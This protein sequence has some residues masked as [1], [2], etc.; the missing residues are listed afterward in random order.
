[1]SVLDPTLTRSQ[2]L[3]VWRVLDP[4]ALG[5]VEVSAIHSMLSSKYGK[6]KGTCIL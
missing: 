1:M 4:Q 5:S 2:L 6:D 3:C